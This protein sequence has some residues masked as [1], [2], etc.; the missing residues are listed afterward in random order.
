M[1]TPPQRCEGVGR[2]IIQ[3]KRQICSC[4]LRNWLCSRGGLCSRIAPLGDIG[5]R[6][7]P[8]LPISPRPSLIGEV[9]NP[10]EGRFRIPIARI[11]PNGIAC[12]SGGGLRIVARGE[13][14]LPRMEI[15][16]P[17]PRGS[18]AQISPKSSPIRFGDLIPGAWGHI[19]MQPP[20][21]RPSFLWVHRGGRL[22]WG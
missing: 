10:S 12:R 16:S 6:K 15:A 19:G 5:G 13:C 11:R 8:P 22:G 20:I 2:P 18:R 14:A 3:S 21:G 7:S 9:R 4:V 17:R 1:H